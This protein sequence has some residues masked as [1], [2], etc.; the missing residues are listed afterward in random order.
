MVHRPASLKCMLLA[1][2][3]SFPPEA[4]RHI[5]EPPSLPF[6]SCHHSLPLFISCHHSLPL[7]VS[8]HHSLPL[9]ISCHH[10]LPLFVSCHHSLP[11]FISCHHSLPLF[12]S[13]HHSLPLFCR[14]YQ[15]TRE[16]SCAMYM[17]TVT[18]VLLDN[19][20][21][22]IMIFFFQSAVSSPLW[23]CI[24]ETNQSLSKSPL[25]TLY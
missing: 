2:S 10:S 3:K 12:V 7:F 25:S 14:K 21:K 8:C 20:S 6:I 22:I 19:Y 1:S 17:T 13:C 15:Q 9:F 11:L 5:L 23:G 4:Y 24:V 16:H 18:A